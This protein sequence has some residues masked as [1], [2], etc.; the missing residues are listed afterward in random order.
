M[1]NRLAYFA[2]LFVGVVFEIAGDV[3]FKKWVNGEGRSY[4]YLG[5]FTY[6]LG[7]FAWLGT[8]EFSDLSKALAT[9]VCL[10]VVIGALCGAFLLGEKVTVNMWLGIAACVLGVFLVEG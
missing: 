1:K 4:I 9:F 3:L 8:L 5:T 10:N 2:L 7:N 6:L